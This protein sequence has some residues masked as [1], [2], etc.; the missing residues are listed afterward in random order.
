MNALGSKLR[1]RREQLGFTL[2]DVEAITEGRI[3]NAYLSQ[4][5][6]DKIARPSFAFVILLAAAYA[7]P[8]ETLAEW[9]GLDIEPVRPNICPGCGQAMRGQA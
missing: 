6:T 3:S 4:L 1:E 7:V 2:R 9:V 5:E 8:I